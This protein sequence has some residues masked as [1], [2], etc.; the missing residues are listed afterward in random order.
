MYFIQRFSLHTEFQSHKDK[1]TQTHIYISFH[2]IQQTKKNTS[3]VKKIDL[4]YV[5]F[6]PLTSNPL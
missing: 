6:S 1:Q 2:H 5:A 3:F 4:Q